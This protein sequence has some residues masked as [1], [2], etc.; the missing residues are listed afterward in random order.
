MDNFAKLFCD[1][2]CGRKDQTKKNI[3]EEEIK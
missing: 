2:C 3:K 1:T